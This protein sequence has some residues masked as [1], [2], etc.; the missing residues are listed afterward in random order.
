[1]RLLP[2]IRYGT[3]RYPEKVARRLRALNIATWIAS[4]VASGFAVVQ[5]L[6][7]TAGL[8]K[9]AAI[10]ALAAVVCATIPL[11]HR[12]GPSA[13]I[14]CFH[15][16]LYAYVSVVLVFL[17]SGTG[18]QFYLD[19]DLRTRGLVGRRVVPS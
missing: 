14:V 8:W 9:V 7:P 11:L 17:G 4:A 12:L 1:M 13:A 16:F 10:N 2:N 5:F 15:I 6:D 3:E 19:P 18:M